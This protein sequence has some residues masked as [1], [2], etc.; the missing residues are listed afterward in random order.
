MEVHTRRGALKAPARISEDIRS[1][2]CFVPFH[3]GSLWGEAEANAATV[4]AF[5]PISKQPELK[6]C[7]ARVTKLEAVKAG[8]G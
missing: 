6:F 1:G 4:D 2:T 5:D 7:A 8:I 3:W